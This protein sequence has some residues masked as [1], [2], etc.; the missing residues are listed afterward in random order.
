MKHPSRHLSNARASTYRAWVAMALYVAA[1]VALDL[2]GEALAYYAAGLA[3]IGM[4]AAGGEQLVTALST[5]RH[6]GE[7]L[8]QPSSQTGQFRT[9]VV[10][11]EM[12]HDYEQVR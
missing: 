9:P 7:G 3:V 10:P 5:L 12:P 6:L 1:G 11:V 2:D 4:W 8:R